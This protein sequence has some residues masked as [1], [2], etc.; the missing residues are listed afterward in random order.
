M[1]PPRILIGGFL[2]PSATTSSLEIPTLGGLIAELGAGPWAQ[3]LWR[4]LPRMACQPCVQFASD[5][6]RVLRT[7]LSLASYISPTLSRFPGSLTALK[8]ESRI[9]NAY[10]SY[11]SYS[12]LWLLFSSSEMT[13]TPAR[14]SRTYQRT[15]HLKIRIRR[16]RIETIHSCWAVRRVSAA[17]PS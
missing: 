15:P 9:W 1:T 7:L 17:L 2:Q 6:V 10:V 3:R 8:G 5:P 11:T 13:W 14:P 4:A 12:Q 16:M